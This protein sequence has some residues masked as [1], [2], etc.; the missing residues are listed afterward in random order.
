MKFCCLIVIL[1]C[2]IH[3]S[4]GGRLTGN[5]LASNGKC[6]RKGLTCD[7]AFGKGWI[8][9]GKCCNGGPCCKLSC[10][11]CPE[12]YVELDDQTASRN[13][14]VYAKSDRLYE[15]WATASFICSSTPGAYLWRP[16]SEEETKAVYK[17][18]NVPGLEFIWT[19]ANSPGQD[20]N[21]VFAVDNG[22]FN[23]AN[24]PFGTENLSIKVYVVSVI[25]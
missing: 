4:T 3:V 25:L 22:V 9:K 14:Y 20:G 24:L 18:F 10:V 7:D 6:G 2:T 8:E 12:G 13:C 11:P 19:G 15:R 17:Q 5:C 16:N 21:F 23:Y 1:F